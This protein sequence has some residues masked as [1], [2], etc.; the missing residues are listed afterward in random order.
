M[1][2][3][4]INEPNSVPGGVYTPSTLR[5]NKQIRGNAPSTVIFTSPDNYQ[6][7]NYVSSMSPTLIIDAQTGLAFHH[8]VEPVSQ[9]GVGSVGSGWHL[10][11]QNIEFPPNPATKV[12]ERAA[13]QTR[14]TTYSVPAGEQAGLLAEF[15]SYHNTPR[16][17]AYFNSTIDN[18]A[19]AL[20]ALGLTPARTILSEFGALGD[21]GPNATPANTLGLPRTSRITLMSTVRARCEYNGFG[22]GYHQWWGYAGTDM[23][24]NAGIMDSS[25]NT[26]DA[27][28][29]AA[30]IP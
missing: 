21:S 19:S 15:D 30:L 6:G 2:N 3:E 28:L 22:W 11:F 14:F 7:W 18:V 20:P 16:D 23:P 10:A 12:A 1:A 26:F 5:L 27:G 9:E 13:V 24:Y 25:T 17:V 8:Y 29:L 4:P